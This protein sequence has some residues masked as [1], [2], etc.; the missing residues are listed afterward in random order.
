MKPKGLRALG[1]VAVP[2]A[3]VLSWSVLGPR[4]QAELGGIEDVVRRA[5]VLGLYCCYPHGPA[6][7]TL[8]TRPLTVEHANRL[9][10][11]RQ[12]QAWAGKAR[13]YRRSVGTSPG[14]DLESYPGLARVEVKAVVII[15]DPDVV[16]MLLDGR[17]S[18]SR[19]SGGE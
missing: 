9:H 13:V 3:V 16:R 19:G 7:V 12:P 18:G 5:E 10:L 17:W 15:G 6:T 2:A 11:G 14:V 8:S 4:P 1:A